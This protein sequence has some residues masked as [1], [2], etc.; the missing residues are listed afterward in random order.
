MVP[1]GLIP[2]LLVQHRPP[3]RPQAR[4]ARAA[5]PAP[6]A[7]D[8]LITRRALERALAARAPFEP[9]ALVIRTL[10]NPADK[11]TRTTPHDTPPY[12]SREAAEL[13]VERGIAAPDRRSALDRPRAR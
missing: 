8:R 1:A 12:L 4:R 7:R 10:P 2:A 5:S 6:L 9:R 13:L 11:R 3:R